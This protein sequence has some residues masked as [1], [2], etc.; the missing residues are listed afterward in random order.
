MGS[1]SEVGLSLAVSVGT[2]KCNTV[3]AA[4]QSLM[5]VWHASDARPLA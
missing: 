3:A 2:P 5:R 4:V 1:P